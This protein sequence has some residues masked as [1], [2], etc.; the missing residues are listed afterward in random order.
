[1]KRNRQRMPDIECHKIEVCVTPGMFIDHG[2]SAEFVPLKDFSLA[3]EYVVP[4]IFNDVVAM[5]GI[6]HELLT[7]CKK[8]LE[9][10]AQAVMTINKET[11]RGPMSRNEMIGLLRKLPRE[12]MSQQLIDLIDRKDS[13]D[14]DA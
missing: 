9:E 14:A 4:K 12:G 7:A 8:R 10:A 2:D 1:M 13:R 5:K 3:G 6:L 11:A